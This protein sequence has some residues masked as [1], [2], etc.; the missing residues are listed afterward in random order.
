MIWRS[1]TNCF[2]KHN[3]DVIEY[4]IAFILFISVLD[5]KKY[6]VLTISD[7]FMSIFD[8]IPAYEL[9]IYSLRLPISFCTLFYFFFGSLFVPVRLRSHLNFH[10]QEYSEIC[11][12]KSYMKKK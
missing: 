3:I 10:T 4:R 9:E 5:Y 8:R 11:A 6:S 2:L 7:Q 1:A 12:E